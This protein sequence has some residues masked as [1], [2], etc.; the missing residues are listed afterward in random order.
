[1]KTKEVSLPQS[2]LLKHRDNL[3]PLV[4]HLAED[5]EYAAYRVPIGTLAAARKALY[6]ELPRPA[7]RGGAPEWNSVALFFNLSGADMPDG[8]RNTTVQDARNM[9]D[10]GVNPADPTVS[11]WMR[12]YWETLSY[13]NL[14]FGVDTPRN[15]NGM[16][17]VPQVPVPDGNAFDWGKLIE[18]CI[19]A[20]PMA[21][22]EAA[23]R[24]KYKG[25]RWIPSV[26]LVQN[27]WTGASATFWGDTY[28]ID[29][30]T[31]IVGDVTH[32]QYDLGFYN[33][34]GIPA[35]RVRNFWS[36]LSHEFSH[37]FLEFWD[38]YGPAGCTGYWDL[39]GDN[40]PPWFPSEVCS[41]HKRRVGWCDYKNVYKGPYL[42]SRSLTLLP[43]TTS[44]EAYKIVPDP[45][46]TPHEYFILEYR[47]S[48]GNDAWVPD[49]ALPEE[50]LL[51][52]HIN[53]R[54]GVPYLWLLR[55]APY[56]DPEF[57]DFSDK[58]GTLWT[59][60]DR[61]QGILF[62]Q[63]DNKNFTPYTN[64]SSSLYGRRN[65][66]LSITNI[67]IEDGRCKF[68]LEIDGNPSVGWLPSDNDRLLVGRYTEEARSGGQEI[69]CRNQSSSTVLTHRQAQWLA[70]GG[71]S[72]EI[73]GWVFAEYDSELAADLDGDGLDEIF[74]RNR[75]AAGVLKWKV[76]AFKAVT[77][78]HTSI[79]AW[80][81]GPFNWE[82]SGD[83]DGDGCDEIC[84]RAPEW[85]GVIK[86]TE[87][88]L[89][90]ISIQHGP[91]GNFTLKEGDK[92]Y[93]GRFTQNRY[94]EFIILQPDGLGL[95][96]WNGQIQQIDLMTFYS[97]SIGNWTFAAT[98]RVVIGDFDG[99]G[100]DEIY[101]RADK[102]AG[103]L[104]W[105]MGDFQLVWETRSPIPPL[106]PSATSP[107][108]LQATDISYAGQFLPGRDGILQRGSNGVAVLTFE[109]PAQA[110]LVRHY[111]G[112]PLDNRVSL[113]ETDQFILGDFHRIGRDIADPT[114]DIIIDNLTDV[115][116]HRSMATAMLGVNHGSWNPQNPADIN[117][118]MGISWVQNEFIMDDSSLIASGCL[119]WLQ[120]FRRF[121]RKIAG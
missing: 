64:P 75:N 41:V 56:F 84:I 38:L 116:I 4:R 20:N 39:L 74:I 97:E 14:V 36:V 79:D 16:P 78:Q 112:S 26:F 7:L 11:D 5:D 52:I 88:R 62:P 13:G 80:D 32:I 37:N 43:Y 31:Y 45:H 104:K 23:G 42:R 55:D 24:L 28:D 66:G 95:F 40:S 94:D 10:E 27:Y 48:T 106:D 12:N 33:A 113:R 107:V 63:A 58:G 119:A 96:E 93:T 117:S 15:G 21:V 22:W 3:H 44:G 53:E 57:A 1:M 59:G 72:N 35:D 65:S 81:L 46:F 71:H 50:G 83:I 120:F 115:F 18:A 61:L 114:V 109:I 101:I 2:I 103:M 100:L 99:D 60:A 91:I 102:R 86:L 8:Y 17:L 51:I 98:N 9:L 110:M 6:Q 121:F 89:D 105:V 111:L 68:R 82:F 29:G 54:L 25:H 30:H 87:G 34:P 85:L 76:T 19:R 108:P 70:R 77:I 118:A 73:D 69:F 92:E 47:K 90:L 49:G 67:R